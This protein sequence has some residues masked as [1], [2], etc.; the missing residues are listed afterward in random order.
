MQNTVFMHAGYRYLLRAGFA[1]GPRIARRS[2]T[3]SAALALAEVHD[4]EA[5]ASLAAHA[6]AEVY[7]LAVSLDLTVQGTYLLVLLLLLGGG[8]FLTVRDLSARPREGEGR[9][10]RASKATFS[11]CSAPNTAQAPLQGLC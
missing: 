2:C 4:F 7:E 11:R 1:R 5:G 10:V 9:R 6:P 3:A 8:G